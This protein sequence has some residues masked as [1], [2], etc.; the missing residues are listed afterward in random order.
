[1]ETRA[2]L[3]G[4]HRSTSGITGF[5]I[6]GMPG[7]K[8]INFADYKQIKGLVASNPDGIIGLCLEDGE[9]FCVLCLR[10]FHMSVRCQAQLPQRTV[11]VFSA[12]DSSQYYDNVLFYC[13]HCSIFF[14]MLAKSPIP[15]GQRVIPGAS[16]SDFSLPCG[17]MKKG[18]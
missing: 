3:I 10:F 4:V 16:R 9:R 7:E 11:Q 2:Y 14:L 8:V 18:M 13:L 1:M 12:I 5:R 17:T 15:A 6:L